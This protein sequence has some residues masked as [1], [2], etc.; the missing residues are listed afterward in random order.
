LQVHVLLHLLRRVG[1][2]DDLSAAVGGPEDEDAF[3]GS[4]DDTVAADLVITG[5]RCRGG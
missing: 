2:D 5:R 1:P 3:L 4:G